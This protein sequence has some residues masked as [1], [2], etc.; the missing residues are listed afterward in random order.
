MEERAINDHVGSS[1][2]P[3]ASIPEPTSISTDPTPSPAVSAPSPRKRSM[4]S[5]SDGKLSEEPMTKRQ[6][7]EEQ[8]EGQ[9]EGTADNKMEI[10]ESAAQVTAT[11][12]AERVEK[13]TEILAEEAQEAVVQIFQTT[14][15]PP[16][17]RYPPPKPMILAVVT[18]NPFFDDNPH[19]LLERSIALALQ[20]VGFS[21]ASKEALESFCTEASAC[22]FSSF[23]S[24]TRN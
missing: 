8:S 23:S 14:I 18:D 4:S 3:Q 12:V 17:L 10:T 5:R 13:E 16:K 1:P 15:E 24:M 20:H 2:S 19:L 9:A 11:I 22:V 7:V 21:G 6:R